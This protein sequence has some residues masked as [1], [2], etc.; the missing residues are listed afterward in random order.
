M[1]PV[2]PPQPCKP[3]ISGGTLN[4]I[5]TLRDST[6]LTPEEVKASRKCTKKSARQ[7]KRLF[8][9]NNLSKDYESTPSQWTTLRKLRKPIR[10]LDGKLHSAKQKPETFRKYLAQHV[11][12]SLNEKMPP[13]NPLHPVIPEF[14][15]PFT[16]E[17]LYQCLKQLQVGKATGPDMIPAELIKHAP[18][19]VQMFF[20]LTITNVFA[21]G[22]SRTRGCS[23]K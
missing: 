9:K 1:I 19:V 4:L 5:A 18:Y 10:D 17:D 21:R 14:F 3:W 8:T 22:L 20:F 13:Q 6:W 11:W 23:R 2:L 7:D 16:E 12:R 15:R